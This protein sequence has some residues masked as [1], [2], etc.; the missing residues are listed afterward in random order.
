MR[1]GGAVRGVG[2]GLYR[3]LRIGLFWL[4]KLAT[5]I[6]VRVRRRWLGMKQK[7]RLSDL[8]SHLY[9]LHRQ[10]SLALPEDHQTLELFR[11]LEE[12]ERRRQ[13]LEARMQE[14]DRRYRERV[15]RLKKEAETPAG[16]EAG[17]ERAAEGAREDLPSE[18]KGPGGK[19]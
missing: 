17:A 7:R 5:S 3:W 13:S 1:L 19:R 6:T 11:V 12:G 16:P 18:E 15:R 14:L 2:A 4:L 9:E 10:Q 8:G